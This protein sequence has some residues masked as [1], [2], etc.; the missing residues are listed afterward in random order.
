V[1]ST[2][3]K[4]FKKDDLIKCNECG[5]EYPNT[6]KECPICEKLKEEDKNE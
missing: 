3:K 4:I 2:I 6:C 5:N 1:S